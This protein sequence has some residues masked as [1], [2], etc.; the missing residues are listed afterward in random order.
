[1]KFSAM[2][3]GAMSGALGDIFW[4]LAPWITYA[5]GYDLGCSIYVANPTSEEKEYALMARLTRDTTLVSEE[6]LPVFGQTWFKVDP[7]DLVEMHGAMRFSDSNAV[8]TVQLL[9]HVTE[10]VIDSVATVLVAPA[11]SAL[12]PAWPV[13]PATSADWMSLL[14]PLVMFGMLGM[15]MVSAHKSKEEKKELLPVREKRRLLTAGRGA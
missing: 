3:A 2:Q 10:E 7:G 11:T 9:E 1:M 15:V 6:A 4:D 12:P 14:M 5:A 8:L 13:A